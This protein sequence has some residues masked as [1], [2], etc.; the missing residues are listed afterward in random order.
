MEKW[1][2]GTDFVREPLVIQYLTQNLTIEN[3]KRGIWSY[4][5]NILHDNI[6]KVKYGGGNLMVLYGKGLEWNRDAYRT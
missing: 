6:C 4:E 1:Q 5:T 3:W 2:S